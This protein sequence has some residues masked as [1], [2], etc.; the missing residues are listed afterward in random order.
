MKVSAK[1]VG[2]VWAPVPSR[3]LNRWRK[4]TKRDMRSSGF[5]R[6][7]VLA[8]DAATQS[9]RITYLPSVP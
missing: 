5:M 8:V 2:S 6:I 3:R 7:P 1:D 4:S 9:V